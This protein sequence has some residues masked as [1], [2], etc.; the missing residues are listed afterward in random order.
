MQRFK[1]FALS[2]IAAFITSCQTH[3]YSNYKDH[4]IVTTDSYGLYH[5]YP[6]HKVSDG[7]L[8]NA[9]K[10]TEEKLDS[11]EHLYTNEDY[12]EILLFVHGGLNNEA[13][14]IKRARDI[15]ESIQ[16]ENKNSKRKVFPIFITWNSGLFSSFGWHLTNDYAGVNTRDP[17]GA[18]DDL[19]VALSA[20][21]RF[22][23][24]VA[25]GA[26][27][28]PVNTLEIIRKGLL[29][30]DTVYK[31]NREAC[32][33]RHAVATNMK[34]YLPDQDFE[35][36]LYDNYYYHPEGGSNLPFEFSLGKNTSTAQSRLSGIVNVVGFPVTLPLS[37]AYDALGTPSWNNMM[38]RA[39]T[40]T[41][42]H[43][44]MI[45]YE[46]TEAGAE[47]GILCQLFALIKGWQKTKP[48]LKVSLVGHSMGTIVLNEGFRAMQASP[49]RLGIKVDRIIYMGAAC[50]IRDFNDT[51]GN[52]MKQNPNCET[53]NL[54]LHPKREIGEKLYPAAPI[55][56]TGSLLVWIDEFFEKPRDFK[57]RT[58][59]C[60]EN[61]LAAP[62]HLPQ[63]NKF[64][65]K[66][67]GSRMS[68]INKL[69]P[70]EGPQKHG[71]FTAYKFWEP[72]FYE[73][74][75]KFN[76]PYSLVP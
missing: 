37:F 69:V 21:T 30:I 4:H 74:S 65:I 56:V 45:K 8:E 10:A 52:Y 7:R 44:T 13:D 70:Q 11:L 18:F 42:R 43:P 32:T 14:R 22:S 40:L 20:P 19:A 41:Y 58:L 2:S 72:N 50:S 16:R 36:K 51:V 68:F 53:F 62:L 26:A 54:C 34:R 23:T 49:K 6:T 64:H 57:E 27:A 5:H 25:S 71:E 61:C 12:D 47:D 35:N 28:I 39:K 33:L 66:A 67:F 76:K 29:N 63:S 46:D 17:D 55:V 73:P 9:K 24:D 15:T 60:F 3:Y 75:N 48:T 1:I 31:A 38:R 59:G